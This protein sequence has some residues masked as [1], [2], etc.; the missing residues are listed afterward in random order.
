M[1]RKKGSGAPVTST[2]VAYGSVQDEEYVPP[3]SEKTGRILRIMA[4]AYGGVDLNVVLKRFNE[5]VGSYRNQLR[6]KGTRPTLADAPVGFAKVRDADFI[7]IT[8]EELI[9]VTVSMVQKAM[10]DPL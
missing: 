4:H 2:R 5:I 9:A 7:A 3:L 6:V 1:A 8:T 10:K